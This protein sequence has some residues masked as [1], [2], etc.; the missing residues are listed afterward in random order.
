MS[1]P[2]LIPLLVLSTGLVACEQAPKKPEASQPAASASAP[3]VP[4]GPKKPSA[5]DA[6]DRPHTQA[7]LPTTSG[8]IFIGNLGASVTAAQ[9]AYERDP[10]S[11]GKALLVVGPLL[12]R[13]KL[14]GHLDDFSE[15][16]KIC[17]KALKKHPD[18]P[19]LYEL[20]AD[21]L[22][23]AHKFDA[24]KKDAER[25]HELSPST[26]TRA[27]LADL[28]WN[29]GDYQKA[30]D[31]IRALAKESPSFS[32][33]VRLAQLEF[34][35]GN[36]KAAEDNFARAETQIKDPSPVPVAWLNV[37]RGLLNLHTGRFEKAK[38]Y[39][40]EAVERMP[41]YPMAVEH[42]AEIEALLGKEVIAMRRY[43][44]VIH[45]TDDPEFIG[46]LAGVLE[47]LGRTEEAAKLRDRAEKRYD[48]ELKKHPEAMYWHAADFFLSDAK[49]PEKAL[50]L[51]EK[52]LKLRPNA[53]SLAFLA[54]AE[55]EAKKLDAA[56]KHITEALATPVKK[57]EIHWTA[58]RIFRARGKTEESARHEKA[59]LA[60]N[61]KIAV[62]E[63]PLEDE[64]PDPAAKD[65]P[66]KDTPK[67][68]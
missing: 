23:A 37:Q 8:S 57:A 20:R 65:A 10:E 1:M 24:A 18:D 68:E 3:L 28:A 50:A 46:A 35:L 33:L 14:Q 44:R 52:N 30:I 55:F 48:E 41:D 19:K 22:A 15:A 17:S 16:E 38:V 62:L 39:Y 5:L 6:L 63:G 7:E 45:L 36:V 9:E 4:A 27:R 12:A 47:G 43:G 56:E 21:A 29:L 32:T 67:K 40:D 31:E 60:L 53:S 64:K 34:D 59:A 2:R 58:A 49:K 11:L 42:L 13:G 51:L 61:P 66:K 54:A 25:A 26:S